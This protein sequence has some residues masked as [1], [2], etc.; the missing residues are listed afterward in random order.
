MDKEQVA[1]V[2][3]DIGILLAL[4]GE[5]PFRCNAYH[6]A[7]RAIQQLAGDLAQIVAAGELTAI[8]GIGA[9]LQE[10]I[11]ILVTTGTLAFYD[12]LK[13]ATP[14]GLREMLRLPGLGPKKIKA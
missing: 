5:N 2:L 14:P 6:N 10:K 7:A 4:K 11:T 13:E 3:D 9:T 12:E 1:A 8:P